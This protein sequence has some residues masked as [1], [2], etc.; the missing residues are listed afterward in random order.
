MPEQ[1]LP[2]APSTLPSPDRL[3]RATDRV[4]PPPFCGGTCRSARVAAPL[5]PDQCCQVC[6]ELPSSAWKWLPAGCWLRPSRGGDNREDAMWFAEDRICTW[7]GGI[8][9]ELVRPQSGV[10]EGGAVQ[11]HRAPAAGCR[12]V[13]CAPL[14]GVRAPGVVCR[15]SVRTGPSMLFAPQTSHLGAVTHQLLKVRIRAHPPRRRC[16]DKR[17]RR[18]S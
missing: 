12:A 11:S 16:P 1:Q 17:L 2:H 13:A 15:E 6:A 18:G 5:Q 9:R 4:F 8:C 10:H 7:C 3:G 14:R